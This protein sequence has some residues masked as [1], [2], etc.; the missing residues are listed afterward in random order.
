MSE[1]NIAF[2]VLGGLLTT[3]GAGWAVLESA[4][5][6]IQ[7]E[8][9]KLDKKVDERHTENKLLSEEKRKEI[10]EIKEALIGTIDEPGGILATIKSHATRLDNLTV[11]IT[12]LTE[13][14][15]P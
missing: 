11:Q 5:K 13:K 15:K 1:L 12:S 10:V 6:S 2:L 9:V 7:D 3:F 8:I 4:K 14:G